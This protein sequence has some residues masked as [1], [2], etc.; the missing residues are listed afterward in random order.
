MSNALEHS[1]TSAIEKNS[2]NILGVT[3]SRKENLKI[4]IKH[5][6]KRV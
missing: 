4:D 3:L 6:S 2:F 1:A 5:V